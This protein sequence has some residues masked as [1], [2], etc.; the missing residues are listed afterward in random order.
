MS[1]SPTTSRSLLR[2]H[3][4]EIAYALNMPCIE[5]AK[6]YQAGKV[7]NEMTFL[8]NVMKNDSAVLLIDVLI[9]V[10]NEAAYGRIYRHMHFGEVGSKNRG[11]CSQIVSQYA[12]TT[13]CDELSISTGNLATFKYPTRIRRLLVT[14]N[15]KILYSFGIFLN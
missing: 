6:T 3:L 14:V 10:I 7:S 13:Y 15:C 4:T 11:L 5:A 12:S 8:S 1:P 9:H 2:G